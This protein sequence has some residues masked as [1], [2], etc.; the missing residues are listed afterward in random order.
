MLADVRLAQRDDGLIANHAPSTPAEGF[1]G[2]TAALHGSA[3]WG[4]VI[5]LGPWA[6]YEAYG[7]PAPLDE[8][9]DAMER[10]IGY[11]ARSAKEHRSAARVSER[12]HPSPHEQ[13]LWDTG[14]H[15]GEWLEPGAEIDDFGAFVAADKSEVATAYLHRSSSIMAQIAEVL[16]K[17][18]A[19]VDRYRRLAAATLDA[20]QREFIGDDGSLATQSQAGH[21]RAL[22]FGLVPE[23]QRA[24]IA[25]R[26]VELVREA[27]TTVGTGFLSTGMLLAVLADNGHLDVAYELLLQPNAP[28]WM[29][30]IDR[31]ATTVWER[32]N[33]VDDEGVPHESLNHYSKAAVVS[34]LHRY[35][36]GL[37]PTSPGYRTFVV[38]PRTGGGLSLVRQRL[39]TPHGTI[40]IEWRCTGSEF[41][42]H[43]DVPEGSDA[44]I[45]LP[46]GERIRVGPGSH[47]W[48]CQEQWV[49]PH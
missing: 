31:G 43:V 37:T 41:A 1:A 27:G 20:W 8:C 25:D 45:E 30:M 49:D 33:G 23:A 32:W 48:S 11:G 44:T 17:P 6:L 42:L 38:R 10:W 9:W 7:D 46:A 16:D 26:L 15:W 24:T 13:F 28:G 18:Q 40:E 39:D 5:V 14:F 4:D 34:F 22:T 3:G 21:V 2:P 19:T 36:A 35:T 47:D 29:Y 12:T